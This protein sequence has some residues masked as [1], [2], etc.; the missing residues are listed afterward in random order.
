YF[1]DDDRIAVKDARLDHRVALDLQR[2]VLATGDHV[3][4]N[5][6]AMSGVLDSV[7]RDTSR[8]AAHDRDRYAAARFLEARGRGFARRS[9]RQALTALYDRRRK[10]L[11]SSK[12]R[13]DGITQANNL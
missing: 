7:D 1:A 8:D 5:I 9:F 6:D 11:G 10:T 13:R 3:R 4:W 12:P 2:I